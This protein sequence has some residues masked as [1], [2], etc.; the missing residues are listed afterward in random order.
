MEDLDLRLDDQHMRIHGKGGSVRAV[1]LNDRGHTTLLK[2]YLARA[3]YTAGVSIEAVRRRIGHDSTGTTQLN[4][5]LNDKVADAESAPPATAATGRRAAEKPLVRWSAEWW[6][7][8]DSNP[9]PAD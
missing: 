8:R 9:G 5:L 6:G 3:G 4:A 1:L 7:A 2:L